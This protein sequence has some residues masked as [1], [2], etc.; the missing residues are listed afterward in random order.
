L[1]LRGEIDKIIQFF[2]NQINNKQKVSDNPLFYR[3]VY[4][5][6]IEEKNAVAI[7]GSISDLC[8]AIVFKYLYYL[9]VPYHPPKNIKQYVSDLVE[10]GL[11]IPLISDNP[12]HSN[13]KFVSVG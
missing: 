13:Q 2:W 8:N 6:S 11:L 9:G 1:S 12:G 5:F 4:A 10:Y 7:E 3:R